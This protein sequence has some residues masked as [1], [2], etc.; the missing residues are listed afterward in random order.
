MLL[1]H[2][3]HLNVILIDAGLKVAYIPI[4][5]LDRLAG[6]RGRVENPLA[7]R[8]VLNEYESCSLPS[9]KTI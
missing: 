8:N 1:A 6:S 3:L 5:L 7:L 4:A 2:H 9:I